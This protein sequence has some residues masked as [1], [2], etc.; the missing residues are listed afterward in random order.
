VSRI[1]D[2]VCVLPNVTGICQ[3]PP[4]QVAVTSLVARADRE[5]VSSAGE[6]DTARRELK[7]SSAEVTVLIE[8]ILCA[9]SMSQSDRKLQQRDKTPRLS[10]DGSVAE[11][12]RPEGSTGGEASTML[13]FYASV[14]RELLRRRPSAPKAS[15]QQ[16]RTKSTPSQPEVS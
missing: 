2:K 11:V 10:T 1:K 14:L 13:T 6:A 9:R 4:S 15:G 16:V 12:S 8:I 3:F 7:K 5:R